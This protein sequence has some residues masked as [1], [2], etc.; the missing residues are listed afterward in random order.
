MPF[1][2]AQTPCAGRAGA[3]S[4]RRLPVLLALIAC[5][6]ASVPLSAQTLNW[7]ANGSLPV[8]GN[9][10]VTPANNV[11]NTTNLRWRNGSSY[12][13][14]NN[15][16]LSDAVFAGTAGTVTLGTPIT[17]HNLTFSSNNYSL[18]GNALTLGGV[19]PTI[20]VNTTTTTVNSVIGGTAGL[21]KAGAGTLVLAGVNTYSGITVVQSGTLS[22]TNN[23]AL[24][25]APNVAANFV[26][27]NGTTL[28]FNSTTL[29][30]NFT[31]NGG[32]VRMT[33]AAAG[34][35]SGSPTLTAASELQ[36][37]SNGAFS[38]N[39]ADTGANVLSLTKSVGGTVILSGANTY[40]GTTLLSAGILRLSSAGA[41]SPN[42]NLVL[43]GSGI[44]ELAAGDLTRA[45]GTGANQVQWTG[46]A[47]VGALGATRIVNLGG[48]G[49]TLTWGSTPGFIGA[50]Q[51]LL[52]SSATSTASLDWRN[53]LD[54]NAGVRTLQINNGTAATDVLLSAP[55]SNGGL[56]YTGTGTVQ[57]NALNTYTGATTLNGPVVRVSTIGNGGVSGGLGAADN[58]A[59]NLVFGNNSSILTYTGAGEST[60]RNFSFGSATQAQIAASG[61]GA[62][63]WNGAPDIASGARTLVLRG[64][65][66]ARTFSPACWRTMPAPCL[67][68]RPMPACGDSP[69][70][71]RIRA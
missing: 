37:I 19:N 45:V 70:P 43:S 60:D 24:G 36:L 69:A 20:T 8:N 17:V 49:D 42:S 58:S 12:Q 30:R 56:I 32:G 14:W 1:P 64:T 35:Y 63:V 2:S 57:L 13:A 61:A 27:N 59:A 51:T 23:A 28:N 9:D 50:G 7:D 3:A 25:A 29:D 71:T 44:L 16:A 47:G 11:W 39:F 46:A 66:T 10:T 62:L 68:R 5:S 67:S 21:I 15:A 22:I 33:A 65:N 48:A 55:I 53:P 41:L 34:V 18:T 26:L 38:G 54:L 31:L 40:S 4:A 6:V 52:L